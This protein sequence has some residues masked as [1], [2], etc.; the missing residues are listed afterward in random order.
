MKIAKAISFSTL[1]LFLAL[2]SAFGQASQTVNV[3]ATII[4]GLSMTVNRHLNLGS[5]VPSTSGAIS[6]TLDPS[7]ASARTKTGTG[8][9]IVGNSHASAQL[10]VTGQANTQVSITLP[11]SVIV[12]SGSNAMEITNFNSSASGNSLTLDQNGSAVFYVGTTIN[13]SQNQA[14]GLYEGSFQVVVN[15]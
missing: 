6:V 7:V 13:L 5:I 14:V 3:N 10:S 4:T 11:N 15:Y 12:L 1:L 9:F 8:G 2:T